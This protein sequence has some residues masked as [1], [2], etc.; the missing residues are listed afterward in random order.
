MEVEDKHDVSNLNNTPIT[1]L[2]PSTRQIIVNELNKRKVLAS[3]EG[4][5]RDWRGLVHLTG[6]PEPS[7]DNPADQLLTVWGRKAE[8]SLAMLEEFLGRMDRW[9][10]VDDIYHLIREDAKIY[11]AGIR[12]YTEEQ[13]ADSNSDD[14]VLTFDD[15][16]RLE[17]GK[18]PQKYD[19]LLLYADQD[20][21]FARQ[22][23]DRLEFDYNLK[24]C[25]KEDL[26][27]G[28]AFEHQGLLKLVSERCHR[29]IVI[30]SRYFF[31]SPVNR[32]IISFAQALAIENRTRIIIP[33]LFESVN[34]ELP[35]EIRMMYKLD[36]NRANQRDY[37][38]WERLRDSVVKPQLSTVRP[39]SVTIRELKSNEYKR[40]KEIEPKIPHQPQ[41]SQY[42]S[43]TIKCKTDEV[44]VKESF[45]YCSTTSLNNSLAFSSSTL[46]LP[47][48]TK[49]KKSKSPSD[50]IRK[51]FR[52][53]ES[54]HK[55]KSKQ[56]AVNL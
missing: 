50:F 17:Q 20:Q 15:I 8:A 29:V 13:S 45:K 52:S 40:L 34:V 7:G 30:L 2:R 27:G 10:I 4:L 26:V 28:L 56:I 36:Y 39:S 55:N 53:N 38:F 23:M 12:K 19:A 42:T 18:E 33:C 37:K 48:K 35:Q 46:S 43:E 11:S 49:K 14:V 16:R 1:A 54:K 22:M 21:A 47:E 32:F 31:D 5:P 6:L 41:P 51:L 3:E 9:D 44:E 24:V 25:V